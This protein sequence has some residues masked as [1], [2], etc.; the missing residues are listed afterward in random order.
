MW[1]TL[2]HMVGLE[3]H[4]FDHIWFTIYGQ[5][6]GFQHRYHIWSNI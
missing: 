6:Y 2:N 3:N 4:M 5:T 1:L